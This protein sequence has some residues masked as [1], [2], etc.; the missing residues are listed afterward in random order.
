MGMSLEGRTALV[1]GASRGIGKQI[2]IRLAQ[3]GADVILTSRTAEAAEKAAAQIHG[4]GGKARGVELDVSDPEAVESVIKTLLSDY[5]TISLLVNNAGITRDNLLLRMKREDW[6][7][8]L[9]TNL[10]GVYSLCRALL[11]AM[12][13]A[14]FGRIVNITSV[15]AMMGNPGQVN[16]TAAKAGAEGL[17]RSLAREVASRNVTVNCVAPGFIDT[18]MTRELSEEQRATLLEVVPMKRVGLPED[19][20][21]AVLFLLSSRAD[22]ITGMTL[23]VNGGMFM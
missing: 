21:A 10:T 17:T 15:V 1:T 3:A 13:R 12:L 18:D 16:Y 11:P 6:D 8:V 7:V 20:A 2:A 19:V 5:G 9:S 22:Y 4:D 23:N 14:R